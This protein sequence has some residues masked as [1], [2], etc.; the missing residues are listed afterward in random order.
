MARNAPGQRSS[1]I[2]TAGS[3]MRYHTDGGSARNVACSAS[4]QATSAGHARSWSFSAR[5]KNGTP[6]PASSNVAT[7]PARTTGTNTSEMSGIATRF[8]PR[9]TSDIEPKIANPAGASANITASCTRIAAPT[10]E[11]APRVMSPTPQIIST[12]TATNDSQNPAA[13][14]A[15]GSRIS[16]ATSASDHWRAGPTC[17]AASFAPTYTASMSHVRCVGTDNPASSA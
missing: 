13:S 3:A 15:S 4:A 10:R 9:P 14:G 12:P 7:A 6:Q 11:A 17:R 5:T 16:T 2:S 8:T 1:A